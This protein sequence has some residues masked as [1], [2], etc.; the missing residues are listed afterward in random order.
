MPSYSLLYLFFNLPTL[1]KKKK[2]E[3][4]ESQ[5]SAPQKSP[6]ELAEDAWKKGRIWELA[7][8]SWADRIV[9]AKSSSLISEYQKVASWF[10]DGDRNDKFR[11]SRSA[12]YKI[13]FPPALQ[14]YYEQGQEAGLTNCHMIEKE[15]DLVLSTKI[16]NWI[17]RVEINP[18]RGE[19]DENKRDN[20]AIFYGAPGTGKT[21][22]MKNI[23]VKAN[24]YP[25]V[26][27]KGSNLTPTEND[28]KAEILPLQK[29]AY[30]LSELEWSLVNDY[31][32]EREDNGE[33][34]YLLF[35][36]EANQISNNSLIFQPNELK[37]LKDC[38]E[39]VD[40]TER[41]NNLWVFATNHLDQIEEAVYREGRLSNTLDFSWNWEIFLEHAE[42]EGIQLPQRWQEKDYL[43]PE[44]NEW[45]AK[46]NIKTFE[47]D[48]LGIDDDEPEKPQFW[49]LFITNNPNAQ[50][51]TEE[52]EVDENGNKTSEK[53]KEEIEVGEFLEFF[54]YIKK[55]NLMNYDG[56]FEN[57]SKITIE[58]VLDTR[59]VEL[60][61][62]V[63]QKLDE[64]MNELEK[65]RT[66]GKEQIMGGIDRIIS[67]LANR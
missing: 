6:E 28:Q 55:K 43:S 9:K 54:W 41:S 35:V 5:Q 52:D 29:F 23:C 16:K 21:A 60:I 62:V 4:Q 57:I 34:R 46:F 30:T 36:D 25:L 51:E 8:N 56:T 13:Y 3:K 2:N 59:L 26:E 31:G 48:F 61:E 63:E 47:K 66:E 1:R 37:F 18:V 12:N 40:K 67:S 42:R 20:S 14:D 10:P 39:G 17:R 45:V 58:K 19:A 50:I 53:V 49:R 33:V 7:I 64:L 32:F 15:E 38:L 27:I 11:F 65:S 44:D 24:C 22:T